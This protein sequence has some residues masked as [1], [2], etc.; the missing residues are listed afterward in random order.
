MTALLS[1]AS[2]IRAADPELAATV[3]DEQLTKALPEFL[4][5]N[6]NRAEGLLVSLL[7]LLNMKLKLKKQ[8]WFRRNASLNFAYDASESAKM[9]KSLGLTEEMLRTAGCPDGVDMQIKTSTGNIAKQLLQ[10]PNAGQKIDFTKEYR[11][12]S[13]KVEGRK[14]KIVIEEIAEPVPASR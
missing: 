2:A 5:A 3:T 1:A 13:R 14:M 12:V 7:L 10:G 9:L 4:G 11:L 8:R 6:N